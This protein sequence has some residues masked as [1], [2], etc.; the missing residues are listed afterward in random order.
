MNQIQKIQT[1]A[2]KGLLGLLVAQIAFSFLILLFLDQGN[3]TAILYQLFLSVICGISYWKN[4]GGASTRHLISVALMLS[5]SVIVW[6]FQGHAWQID[7]HMY[8]FAA[9]AMTAA[10]CDRVS[11][12][13]ATITVAIHHLALN[14][15]LPYAVYPDGADFARVVLHAIIVISETAVLL[16]LVHQLEA[17]FFAASQAV[18]RAETAKQEVELMSQENEQQRKQNEMERRS[19]RRQL[20]DD[21]ESSVQVVAKELQ[22]SA[23]NFAENLRQVSGLAQDGESR[24]T[25][26]VEESERSTAN[27]VDVSEAADALTKAIGEIQNRVETATVTARTAVEETT[28]AVNQVDHLGSAAQGI[29]EFVDLITAIAEQTNLLAL[30]ATIEAARAGDAGKGFAVVASEVKALATQTSEATLKIQDMVENIQ[31][32]TG[33]VSQGIQAIQSRISVMDQESSAISEAVTEQTHATSS[34][35]RNCEQVVSYAKNLQ[36]GLT[37][38]LQEFEK[39]TQMALYM[40]DETEELQKTSTG[41]GAEVGAFVKRLK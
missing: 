31:S 35:G 28:Q 17:G 40:V 36:L 8:F 23:L 5:I 13:L 1:G 18:E 33:N 19:Q 22:Q 15:L 4:K 20:A 6:Q 26:L 21:L 25:Q 2:A 7:M 14:F 30:N 38:T 39:T 9:L 41:L 32:L 27:I 16:W 11:L 10:F 34:I 29:R 12:L 37:S 24:I 3:S